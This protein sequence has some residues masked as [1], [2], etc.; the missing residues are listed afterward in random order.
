MTIESNMKIQTYDETTFFQLCKNLIDNN[1]DEHVKIISD[2]LQIKRSSRFFN[3]DSKNANGETALWLILKNM[4]V[5]CDIVFEDSEEN[6]RRKLEVMSLLIGKGSNVNIRKRGTGIGYGYKASM[7][8]VA[9]DRLNNTLGIVK[10]LL[11][12]GILAD[13]MNDHDQTPLHFAAERLNHSTMLLLIQ[14][15]ANVNARDKDGDTPITFLMQSGFGELYITHSVPKMVHFG[16][17]IRLLTSNGANISTIGSSGA[18]PL[19]M[20]IDKLINGPSNETIR[21]LNIMIRSGAD[22]NIGLMLGNDDYYYYSIGDTPLHIAVKHKKLR[23]VK[24]LLH[25]CPNINQ[26]NDRNMSALDY[27]KR[28]NLTKIR[29]A[30]EGYS[31]HRLMVAGY[32]GDRY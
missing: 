4:T 16:K 23:I 22:V 28:L 8:H 25:F 15:G 3:I 27:A 9:C 11:D 26:V 10:L 7:L 18:T 1:D 20:A 29:K 32:G 31:R 5:F 12:N 13:V 14:Y 30:I 24:L 21:L 19:F 17:C 6:E 2:F